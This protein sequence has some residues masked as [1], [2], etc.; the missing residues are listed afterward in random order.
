MLNKK[1]L[2][3]FGFFVV[4]LSGLLVRTCYPSSSLLYKNYIIRKDRGNEILCEPYIVQKSDWVL[5]LFRQKGEI[6]YKNFPEFLRIFKRINQNIDDINIIRPGQRIAIPLKKIRPGSLPGQASGLVTIPFATISNMS[7]ILKANS[8]EYKVQA[9]DCVSK[10]I[11][12]QFSRYGKISYNEG[13]KLFKFINPD[14]VNLNRIYAGQI[15]NVPVPSI[16]KEP[17]YKSLIANYENFTSK[18]YDKE[19]PGLGLHYVADNIREMG[20][21]I[22]K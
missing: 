7:R 14:I 1:S 4:G 18:A 11:S 6:A 5:K 20:G 12:T 9:G 15:I 10:I 16:R 17:S 19:N 3:L 13:I 2:F 22:D 8:F 21:K